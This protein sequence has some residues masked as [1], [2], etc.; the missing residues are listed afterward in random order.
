MIHNINILFM[1]FFRNLVVMVFNQT[2]VKLI[3]L[4]DEDLLYWNNLGYFLVIYLLF[5]VIILVFNYR[6]ISYLK[7]YKFFTE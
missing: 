1:I 7:N 5:R 4:N 2:L 6:I 3:H